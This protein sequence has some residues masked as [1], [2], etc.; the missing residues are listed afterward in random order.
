MKY[1]QGKSEKEV[2]DLFIENYKTPRREIKD[3]NECR[4]VPYS[5]AYLYM[6][7]YC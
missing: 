7:Q 6:T 2:K 5:G 3:L 1:F 4:N